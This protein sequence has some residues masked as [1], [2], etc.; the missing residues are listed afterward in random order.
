LKYE[1]TKYNIEMDFR[2]MVVEDGILLQVT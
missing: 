2:K 1:E